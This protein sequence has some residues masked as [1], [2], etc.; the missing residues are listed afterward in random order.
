MR[1]GSLSRRYG[2]GAPG[3]SAVAASGA[4]LYMNMTTYVSH[5]CGDIP[6]IIKASR[7]RAR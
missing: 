6:L 5:A 2:H 4:N 3:Q 1:L 7:R